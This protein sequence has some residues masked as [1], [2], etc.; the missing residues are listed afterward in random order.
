M[1][2]LVHNKSNQSK[3]Q[4]IKAYDPADELHICAILV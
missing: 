4:Y 2:F 1:Y 3:L